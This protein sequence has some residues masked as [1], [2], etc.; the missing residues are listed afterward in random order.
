M[1]RFTLTLALV[2]IV[3]FAFGQRAIK[4]M[5]FSKDSGKQIMTYPG[6]KSISAL[7]VVF[8]EDFTDSVTTGV[9]GL[10]DYFSYTPNSTERWDQWQW[11]KFTNNETAMIMWPDPG[12]PI[13]ESTIADLTANGAGVTV[14]TNNPALFFDFEQSYY[15]SVTQ[16]DDSLCVYYSIDNGSNWH[17]I[18]NTYDPALVEA[19][20]LEADWGNWGVNTA[21]ILLPAECLGTTNLQL[22]FDYQ[23]AGSSSALFFLYNF[24]IVEMPSYDLSMESYVPHTFYYK[25]GNLDSARADG[26]YQQLPIAQKRN[27]EYFRSAVKSY[28]AAQTNGINISNTLTDASGTVVCQKDTAYMNSNGNSLNIYEKDTFEIEG[29]DASDFANVTVG[30]YTFKGVLSHDNN[31]DDADS[32]NQEW[33]M[34]ITYVPNSY[35]GSGAVTYLS[36]NTSINGDI[37]PDNYGGASGDQIGIS[38][39]VTESCSVTGGLIPM[40]TCTDNAG[41]LIAIYGK[42]ASDAWVQ[43]GFSSDHYCTDAESNTTIDMD[44]QND[45]E[46]EPGKEYLMMAIASWT[47]GSSEVS[48]ANFDAYKGRDNGLALYASKL[49]IGSNWYVIYNVPSF[50]VKLRNNQLV[51][52]ETTL[53]DN[54]KVYPNPTNGT[55]HIDN[56]N[57][58]TVEVYNM[59]GTMVDVINNAS[60]FNTVDLSNYAEGTYMVKVYT[61]AGVVIKKVNLVK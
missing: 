8:E 60:D 40:G 7:T 16:G 14:P 45:V 57:G 50:T 22:K 52:V 56:V 27:F 24:S 35:E 17:M 3:A 54:V 20:G 59:V 19:S 41:F 11:H 21:R 15:W 10:P 38:F 48:F 58:A 49:H 28:G 34:D 55:L 9:N 61:E 51:N 44:L 25:D 29:F 18:W 2:A 30:T 53:E 6:E 47:A 39:T 13:L 46:L 23:G 33:S 1:R 37:S 26:I 32:T 31:A 5:D 4:Q 42:D 12:H 43:L 36:R